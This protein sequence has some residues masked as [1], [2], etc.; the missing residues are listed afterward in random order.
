MRRN[1]PD[2][3]VNESGEQITEKCLRKRLSRYNVDVKRKTSKSSRGGQIPPYGMD[4]DNEFY[5][6]LKQRRAAA[7]A[8]NDLSHQVK[9]ILPLIL[10]TIFS[11]VA[12]V[13]RKSED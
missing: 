10:T 1:F 12:L 6:E 7:L 4:I 2:F 13:M 9:V 5:L 3:F 11:R 8:V